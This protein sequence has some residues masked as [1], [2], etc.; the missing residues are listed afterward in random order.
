MDKPDRAP[1]TIPKRYRMS[2]KNQKL[3]EEFQEM[4]RPLHEKIA[5]QVEEMN[6]IIRQK[7]EIEGQ[8]ER[9]AKSVKALVAE[10]DR[11]RTVVDWLEPVADAA[12]RYVEAVDLVGRN[13]AELLILAPR[14][15]TTKEIIPVLDAL[16]VEADRNLTAARH[17]LTALQHKVSRFVLG[18]RR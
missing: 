13:E 16:T 11:L 2:P 7:W 6:T 14:E 15:E 9:C 10:R 8:L 4:A 18:E 1:E 3:Y 17:C 12:Q 5:K